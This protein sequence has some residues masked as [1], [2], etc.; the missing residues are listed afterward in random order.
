MKPILDLSEY[1]QIIKDRVTM[2]DI[3]GGYFPNPHPR[4]K[5][6]PC[7]L[8]GGKDYNFSYNRKFYKCFVCGQSGD[9][10]KFVQ[11][12]FNIS[13]ADAIKKINRDFN[14]GL[15]IDGDLDANTIQS[16]QREAERRKAEREARER[17][18][19]AAVARYHAAMD[20]WVALD[21]ALREGHPG[22]PA[23]DTAERD[24]AKANYLLD[25][26]EIN[27]ARLRRADNC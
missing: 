6:I 7:P 21:R 20:R 27:L 18:G 11:T 19:E 13:F 8:H 25:V 9:V 1:A 4:Y 22:D 10:I 24:I 5:R 26:E 12:H 15:P 16:L 3:V 17:E 2:D 14:V 23:Y